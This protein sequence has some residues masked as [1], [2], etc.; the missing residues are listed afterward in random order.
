MMIRVKR[1]AAFLLFSVSLVAV[2]HVHAQTT[3]RP[4]EQQGEFVPLDQLPPQEQLP[5]APLLVGA[6][7]FVMLALFAYLF[8]VARRLKTV[9]REVERLEGDVKRSARG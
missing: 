9:E 4:P 7:V 2:P 6:Y 3:T 8:S 1:A 5:A